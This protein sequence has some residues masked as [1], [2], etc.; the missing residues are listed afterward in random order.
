MEQIK[1]K[2]I[3]MNNHRLL[4]FRKGFKYGNDGYARTIVQDKNKICFKLLKYEIIT[5]F[6]FANY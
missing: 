4:V 1:N 3:N 2:K 6:I 5:V